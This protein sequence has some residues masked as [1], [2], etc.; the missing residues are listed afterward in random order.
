MVKYAQS[1]ALCSGAG[2]KAKSPAVG[3]QDEDVGHGGG[4]Q[5]CCSW[6]EAVCSY[7]AGITGQRCCVG[8][9]SWADVRVHAGLRAEGFWTGT[10]IF[11]GAGHTIL[12]YTHMELI[13]IVSSLQGH[14]QIETSL[15][16]LTSLRDVRDTRISKD[17]LH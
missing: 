8:F 9:G 3:R 2:W 1:G 16:D 7:H 10:E 12:V 5:H 15:E 17:P 6:D 14:Y 4:F 13:F 11:G